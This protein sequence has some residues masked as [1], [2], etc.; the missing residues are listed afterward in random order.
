M[1]IIPIIL[2]ILAPAALL[3]QRFSYGQNLP[4]Y[5]DK[6]FRP[7]FFVAVNYA[8][9]RLEHHPEFFLPQNLDTVR[10][11]N[12]VGSPGITLGFIANL[13]LHDQVDVRFNPGVSFYQRGVEYD[14]ANGGTEQQK[15]ENTFL[16]FPLLLKVRSQRRD[17]WR[18]YLV[19]GAKYSL[20]VGSRRRERTDDQLRTTSQDLA[21]EFGFGFDFY[22]E[23]FKFAPEIRF[24]HG[25]VNLLNDDPNIYSQSLLNLKSQTLTLYLNFE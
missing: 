19:G 24:S 22:F 5:D 2:L 6:W 12:P 4:Y 8:T 1:R 11:L 15:V 13:R 9:Y 18:V 25:L 23:M 10:A 3:A 20:E 21:L 16:E 7:G 17:N 14:F